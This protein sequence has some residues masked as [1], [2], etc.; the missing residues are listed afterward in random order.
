MYTRGEVR[1]VREMATTERDDTRVRYM[2]RERETEARIERGGR[3]E[4]KRG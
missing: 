1:E 3:R 2:D 4:T